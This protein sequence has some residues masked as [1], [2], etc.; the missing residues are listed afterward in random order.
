MR[1][2]GLV[3]TFFAVT[4]NFC[5]N[6]NSPNSFTRSCFE[7][8]TGRRQLSDTFCGSKAYL[9][10]EVLKGEKY[11]PLLSDVWSMGAVLYVLLMNKLPFNDESSKQ[12]LADQMARNY[13][14]VHFH[15]I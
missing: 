7:R 3:Y 4:H 15:S 1:L 14:S 13:K 5:C 9:A 6:C 8:H 2:G 12:L 10:P 11:N